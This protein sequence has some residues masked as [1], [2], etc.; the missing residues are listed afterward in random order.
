MADQQSIEQSDWITVAE[1]TELTG[2]SEKYI[3]QLIHSGEIQTKPNARSI[4]I[5]RTALLAAQLDRVES[6][7]I[8]YPSQAALAAIERRC[9]REWR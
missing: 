1:A 6:D 2:G 8:L 4:L 7:Q 5:K 9:A 3:L